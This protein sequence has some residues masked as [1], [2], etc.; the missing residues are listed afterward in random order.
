[1]SLTDTQPGRVYRIQATCSNCGNLNEYELPKGTEVR[2]TPC[3]DC[4]CHDLS[5]LI[6]TFVGSG[7]NLHYKDG[8]K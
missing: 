2:D 4:E 5:P 3:L 6:L 1:M 8:P 7:R